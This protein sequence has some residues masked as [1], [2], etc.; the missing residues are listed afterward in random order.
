MLRDVGTMLK[1]CWGDGK[2]MLGDVEG[3]LAH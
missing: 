3:M 1:E 2:G